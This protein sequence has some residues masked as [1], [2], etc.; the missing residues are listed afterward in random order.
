MCNKF[1]IKKAPTPNSVSPQNKITV[2]AVVNITF[3]K[4]PSKEN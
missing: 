3:K 2:A 1:N 4:I